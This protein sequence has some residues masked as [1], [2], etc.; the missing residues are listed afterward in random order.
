[1]IYKGDD[2]LE[3][4]SIHRVL[5][6]KKTTADR[7]LSELEN[8]LLIDI[9]Q[10]NKSTL[11]GVAVEDIEKQ[12]ISAYQKINQLI[13]NY[14]K[15]KSALL[16]SNAGIR[17]N[18]E[19]LHRVEVCGRKYT[20]AELIFMSDEIYGNRRHKDAFKQQLLD[21]MKK[22]YSTATFKVDRQFQKIEDDIKDYLANAVS[23]DKGLSNEEI[24]KRSDMF[25]ADGDFSLIDPL[26]LRDKI[27]KLESEIEQFRTDCDA[28][29]SEQNALTTVE[30]DLT[31]DK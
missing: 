29:I 10:G 15:I 18:V 5:A 9:R 28:V 8:S 23:S 4:L 7:I 30:I 24:K 31:T 6:L 25:H 12:I 19:N 17:G 16:Q 1:M 20:M 3:K 22:S 11:R 27:E 14:I 21:K 13:S 2:R 26:N